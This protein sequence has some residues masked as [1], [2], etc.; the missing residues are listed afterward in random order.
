M[1]CLTAH[2]VC[3]WDS[4]MLLHV[5]HSFS[6]Y[7]SSIL[8]CEYNLLSLLLD[9]WVVSDWRLLEV[10]LLWIFLNMS[11]GRWM[12]FSFGVYLDHRAC[13]YLVFNILNS[14]PS[15]YINFCTAVY[16]S[17]SSY[18]F[19]LIVNIACLFLFNPSS[20]LVW[21][22]VF[23]IW[24]S[25]M[26]SEVEHVVVRTVSLWTCPCPNRWNLWTCH[27]RDITDVVLESGDCPKLSQ[28]AQ[29]DH[30]GP[31]KC[32]GVERELEKVLWWK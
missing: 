2:Q 6:L 14:F 8:L 21:H 31:Y 16:E 4:C 1:W 15:D 22:I 25:L 12:C 11:F 10:T 26:V 19:L 13:T 27:K 28:Q 3:L 24:F 18:T 23:L 9:I 7:L 5:V 20:W 30:K 32:K 17:S 29:C